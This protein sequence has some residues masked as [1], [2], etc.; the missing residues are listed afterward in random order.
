MSNA[1]WEAESHREQ[2][3]GK[4][5]TRQ[6]LNRQRLL[7]DTHRRASAKVGRWESIVSDDENMFR[8]KN[9]SW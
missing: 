7:D 2:N 1:K 6:A 3:N 4:A 8:N 5:W 9:K